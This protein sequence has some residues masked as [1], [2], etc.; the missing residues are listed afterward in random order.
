VVASPEAA[1]VDSL[2]VNA[3]YDSSIIQQ[4]STLVMLLQPP[5]LNG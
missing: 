1:L 3:L 4:E 5:S 2:T